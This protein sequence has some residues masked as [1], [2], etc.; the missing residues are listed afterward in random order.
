MVVAVKKR[1]FSRRPCGQAEGRQMCPLA[2]TNKIIH[3]Q[4]ISEVFI[5]KYPG[6]FVQLAAEKASRG[7]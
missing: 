7:C 6:I 3:G 5:G 1:P 2:L 4:S